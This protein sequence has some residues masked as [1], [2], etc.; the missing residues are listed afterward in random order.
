MLKFRRQLNF[1]GIILL[2]TLLSF[3]FMSLALISHEEIPPRNTEE[4]ATAMISTALS[5]QW[6]YNKLRELCGIGPRLSGSENSFRAIEWAK[7]TMENLGLDRVELQPVMVPHWVR[8]DTEY[9]GILGDREL[10]VGALG[11]SIATP[12]EGIT[13]EVYEVKS[14]EEL[15]ANTELAGGKIIFFNQAMDPTYTN[16]FK[17]YEVAVKQRSKGAIEAAKAGG[18]AA[19]VRSVTTKYDNVPHVG[20]M[21]YQEQIKKVPAAA[22]SLIDAD[23]LSN[24]LK[25]KPDLKVHLMLKCETLPDVE[26]YNVIG[27]ISGL[28]YPN[29][30]VLVGGHFDS[31]DKGDGA[32]DDGAGCIQALE[33]LYLLK[34][35]GIRPQRTVRCVFFIN[36][37]NGIRGAKQYAEVADMQNDMHHIAAIESDR[38]AFTP[39]GFTVDAEKLYVDYLNNWL[40]FLKPS[41]INW[42]KKGYGGVDI[43]QLND[44]KVLIGF[45]PDSQRYFDYHHSDNDVFDAVHPREMELGSAAI[46][47]L[48]YLL[49]E[50]GVPDNII[51]TN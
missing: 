41:G 5:E 3:I 50:H 37:E 36:E 23:N 7:N 32:H 51:H 48:T 18:V 16:T 24:A 17:A 2:L 8:G 22:V 20:A 30:I 6:G 27:E 44:C 21:N 46:G 49:S 43:K 39:L 9:A 33:A 31:W 12:P 28:M 26:S 19:L 42:I 38:G 1:T 15:R 29:E 25:E 11:R 10:N 34:H 40:D 14:F 35:L 4:I 45:S 47:I 13:A